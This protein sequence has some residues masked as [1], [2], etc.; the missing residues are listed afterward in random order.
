MNNIEFKNEDGNTIAVFKNTQKG[1]RVDVYSDKGT[2]GKASVK[3]IESLPEADP[4]DA[5]ELAQIIQR[6]NIY[7][8]T[9]SFHE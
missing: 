8:P 6:K 5:F 2:S 7:R 3:Y 9:R 1:N 4:G